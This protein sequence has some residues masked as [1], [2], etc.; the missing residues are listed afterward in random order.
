MARIAAVFLETVEDVTVEHCTFEKIGGNALMVSGESDR[1]QL[2]HNNVS[3]VGANAIAVLARVGAQR[4]AHR[5]SVLAHLLVPRETNISFNQVHHV[6]QRV[7]HA[8][9]IMSVGAYQTTIDQN[10]V[11]AVAG[12]TYHVANA[13]GA[14]VSDGAP[15]L[16]PI[17]PIVI[18]ETLAPNLA[19]VYTTTVAVTGFDVPVI[20]KLI[21]APPCLSGSGRTDALYGD[22]DPFTY[23][24]CSGCCSVHANSAKLRVQGAG[25]AWADANARAVVFRPGDTL[26][27]AVTSSAFFNSVTDVYVGFHVVTPNQ[28]LELSARAQWRVRTRA[29]QYAER[30]YTATCSGPCTS[31]SACGNSNIALQQNGKGLTCADGY[32]ADVTSHVCNGPFEAWRDCD[33]S[34]VLRSHVYYDCFITC[35]TTSCA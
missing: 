1:V 26:E 19:S 33:G 13:N 6:G 10:L 2:V 25:V 5:E 28:I 11:F 15:L 3:F 22:P 16:R 14:S 32:E 9:A 17:A 30:T 31:E 7:A 8:A 18:P 29:C 12:A 35:F 27:L 23:T 20:A 24:S 21:G 4:N 34:G